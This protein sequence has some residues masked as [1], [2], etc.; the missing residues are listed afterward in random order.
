MFP[1]T[2][3]YWTAEFNRLLVVITGSINASFAPQWAAWLRSLRPRLDLRIVVTR[4][5]ERFVTRSGISVIAD[6]SAILDAWDNGAHPGSLH[7]ALA[8]WA[9]AAIIYPATFHYLARLSLGL[10]DTPSLLAIQCMQVP[11][12]VAPALPPGGWESP[13]VAEHL[14]RLSDRPNVSVIA[15]LSGFSFATGGQNGHHPPPFWQI[16]DELGWVTAGSA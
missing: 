16:L 8:E 4:S 1:A 10:A 2:Q 7:T 5:A 15:P 14:R 11:V 13:A 6:T 9:Q 3:Y 12:I